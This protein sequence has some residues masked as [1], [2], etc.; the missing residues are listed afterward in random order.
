ME[1]MAKIDLKMLKP[2]YH[3]FRQALGFRAINFLKKV[4]KMLL[5]MIFRLF[6]SI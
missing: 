6:L 3:S 2:T 4:S 1:E 5:P